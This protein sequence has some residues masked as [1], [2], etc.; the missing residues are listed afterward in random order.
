MK[1]QL[2]AQGRR[3]REGRDQGAELAKNHG[4]LSV[5]SHR[6]T[7]DDQKGSVLITDIATEL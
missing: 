4:E 5:R 3:L 7:W 6:T 1:G 2:Q